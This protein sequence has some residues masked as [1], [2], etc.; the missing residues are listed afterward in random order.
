MKPKDAA[1]DLIGTGRIVHKSPAATAVAI[2]WVYP[3]HGFAADKSLATQGM[4][5]FHL[6]N[7]TDS[8]NTKDKKAT[9]SPTS[10]AR[11]KSSSAYCTKKA[12]TSFTR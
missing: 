3:E 4:S 5:S 8:I 9:G 11:W 6:E 2:R 12:T 1:S 7:V 10:S